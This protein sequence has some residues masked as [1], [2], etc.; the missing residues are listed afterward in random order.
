[1][2]YA[3]TIIV[4]LLRQ[5]DEWLSQCLDSAVR[6][7]VPCEVLVVVSHRTPTSNLRAVSRIRSKAGNLTVLRQE[8]EGF[9]GA[10]NTGIHAAACGRVGFLL[11]DDWLE[12]NAAEECLKYTED[13]VS[14]GNTVYAADGVTCLPLIKGIPS[15]REYDRLPTLERKARYLSHFFLFQRAKLLEAGGL[16][17]ALGNTPGI[18][19]YDLIW[20]L[21]EH[22]ASVKVIERSLYNYRDH[23]GERLTL[24]DPAEMTETMRKILRKHRMP[25]VEL[26]QRLASSARWFGR[27]IQEVLSAAGKDPT[28]S[29]D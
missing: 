9:P 11:S 1:M 10:I 21:L 17:E 6:Q 20:V 23:N 28:K 13:I 14:A 18:D 8:R 12:P 25:E 27:P 5:K 19:D 26:E 3:A 15:A 22:S 24:A 7:T 29:G 16:D 4:P 2:R